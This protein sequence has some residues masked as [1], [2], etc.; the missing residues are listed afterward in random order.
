[1]A[2]R[3]IAAVLKTVDPQGSVGSNPTPSATNRTSFSWIPSAEA[4]WLLRGLEV[5]IDKKQRFLKEFPESLIDETGS[6][7]VGAGISMEAGYPSWA[8]LLH[9]IADE[10]GVSSTDIQ[11]L[12]ALAQWSI[13]E[14][15]SA[16]RVHSVI[17]RELTSI[18]PVPKTLQILARLPIRHIWTTNYDR[19]IERAFESINRPIDP[20]STSKDL[21][22]KAKPGAA[23]LY[24]MHGCVNQPQHVVISTDDYELYRSKRGAYLPVLQAH[25]TSMSMLFVG[26]SLTDPNIRHVLSLIRESFTDSPPEHFAIVRRPKRSDFPTDVE[27]N[28]KNSQHSYW[29]KDLQRYGLFAVEVDGY[30]EIPELLAEVERRVALQ[31]ILV[32]GSYPLDFP[33]PEVSKGYAVAM[34]I[35]H[36]IGAMGRSLV[37]GTG[38]VVG[39]AAI[40]GFLDSLRTTGGWDLERR[41]IARPFPQPLA[42]HTADPNQYTELRQELTRLAGTVVFIGGFKLIGGISRTAEGVK[43]EW[44]L[45]SK[46]GSFLLP[47][48]ATGGAAAEISKFL[49]GSSLA[50]SGPKPLRPTDSELALLSDD[51]ADTANLIELAAKILN[52]VCGIK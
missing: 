19:L 17:K 4:R 45:A 13:Q 18:H 27:F 49:Q 43:E 36:A 9:E 23:R 44:Q 15:G 21:A 20:I 29:T 38:S 34:G 28:S 7:F 10:L 52:R 6:I 35:G 22:L 33:S 12:A 51:R 39:P 3:P 47:I 37:S 31:R 30:D 16:S 40:G 11:D 42:G 25:L 24:K 50:S 5:A 14:N 46:Q 41:L 48:G 8:Q 1:M 2:E 26:L 32:S